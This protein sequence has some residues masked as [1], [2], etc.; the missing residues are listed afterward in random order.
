MIWY[1][2]FPVLYWL[3]CV[4]VDIFI[5]GGAREKVMCSENN[6]HVAIVSSHYWPNQHLLCK[7][8]LPAFNC[9]QAHILAGRLESIHNKGSQRV[10]VNGVLSY[11]HPGVHPVISFICFVHQQVLTAVPISLFIYLFVYHSVIVSLLSNDYPD[12]DPVVM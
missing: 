10:K 5:S 2:W 1:I 8:L 7:L 6:G 12:H 9:L 11:V 3:Q 4:Q